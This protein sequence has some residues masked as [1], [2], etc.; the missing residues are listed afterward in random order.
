MIAEPKADPG[1][2]AGAGEWLAKL[3]LITPHTHQQEIIDHPARFKVLACGRRF[4]KTD[5]SIYLLA[6]GACEGKTMAYF[7]PTYKNASEVWR[8][9]KRNLRPIISY[10]NETERRIETHSGGVIELWSLDTSNSADNVRGRKYHGI[11]V[12]EAAMVALPDV[13]H[14]VLRPL[15]TDYRGWALFPSTPKGYNWF[16]ELY[17]QGLDPNLPDWAC[18]NYPTTANPYIDA[19]EVEEARLTSPERYFRQEYLAEFIED[20]GGVF[21][22][23][24]EVSTAQPQ[25]AEPKG[26]YVFG[27]DWGR[28]HDFTVISVMDVRTKRQVHLERFNQISWELQRG[29]LKALADQY[30][31]SVIYAE[32][33]S[34]GEVNIEA[35]QRQDKLPVR[36]FQT[37]AHSKGPL[38]DGLALAIERKD[39]TLLDDPIQKHELKG[40]QMERL[41]SGIFRYGAPA[42]GFDD[43]VI[44]TALAWYGA[45]NPIEIRQHQE[46]PFYR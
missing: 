42:G 35:L 32:S 38:V 18:W 3:E 11:V 33:N 21:R 15:L 34:I 2:Q 10:K 27:V 23:V 4:G 13:W 25:A 39:V 1:A 22:G 37:T 9:L 31:P 36:P 44:A 40:Y 6:R 28:A 14:A 8:G 19:A 17:A 16:R 26:R 30:R 46:N 29:R 7:A 45:G 20:A 12:D 24:D 43:T 41:P 5:L